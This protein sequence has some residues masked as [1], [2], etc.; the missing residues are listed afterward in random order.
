MASVDQTVSLLHLLG[1]TTRVRLL[2]LLS[3][4]E[5]TVA[6]L[7]NITELP[8]SRVST[9]L[10]RLREAGMLRDRRVGAS[11]FYAL[12]DA[13]MPSEARQVWGLVQDATQDAVLDADRTRCE[14]LRKAR[15]TG[16]WPDS[17]A[18]E[19]ERHYSPGRTWEATAHAL[20][21]FVSL[22][23][24]LDLGAGDGAI[25]QLLLPRCRSVTCLDRSEKMVAAAKR[26]FKG[27]R[28]VRLV[29]GDLVELPFERESFDHVLCSSVL[30]YVDEP[31]R[32]LSEAARVLRPGG[33]L[34]LTTLA[35]H[36]HLGVTEAYGHQHAGFSEAVLGDM[37]VGA[38]LGVHTCRVTS[39]ERKKPYFEVIT[40]YADKPSAA[41]PHRS[42]KNGNGTR[43]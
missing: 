14:L 17:I 30:T 24:L 4:E 40:A 33:R 38:G 18:G 25:A 39:R 41:S 11:T 6:E 23:D 36:S 19:M 43:S 8:Q 29:V 1:D 2:A 42:A 3:R 31:A 21:G 22:G 13:A 16:S 28:G 34:V 7:T 10:G 5:L 37:L 27:Q 15:E 32:A 35:A 20:L 12:N 9:H 26:R